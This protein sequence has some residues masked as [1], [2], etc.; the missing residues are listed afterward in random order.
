V[1][2]AGPDSVEPANLARTARL[3]RVLQWVTIVWN[4]FEVF[5]TI[6]LGLAAGSLAL[7]AFGLDSLVEV[8][9]SAVVVWH[10]HPGDP[11]RQPLRDRRAGRL[12]AVA[13][14][15]LAAYLFG[16][17]VRALLIQQQPDASPFGIAYL[18]VTA[19]VM[20]SLAGVKRRVGRKL[21]SE[22]FLAEAAMTRLDGG[23]ATSILVALVLNLTLAWWW[24]DPLA[25]ALI[26]VVAATEAWQGWAQANR[27]P[28]SLR[29]YSESAR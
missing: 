25:A 2:Y 5:V 15:A 19:L 28:P 12:V 3:G 11:S 23:L 9:A 21:H 13:F 24:V 1:E 29:A 26:G 8:F 10:L 17:G 4:G 27:V 6:G 16:A 14:A 7:I 20:F 18:G 22:P